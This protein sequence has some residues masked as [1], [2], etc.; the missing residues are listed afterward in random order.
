MAATLRYLTVQDILWIN[1][2]VT[3]KVNRYN[4]AAL[5]EATFYQY[6]YGESDEL[7]P[8][9]ARFLSGFTRKAAFEVGN[10][11]TAFVA[12][13][14]F[15][16]LNHFTQKFEDPG[17]AEWLARALTAPGKQLSEGI[18][19][20]HHHESVRE[21]VTAVVREYPRTI[22]DLGGRPVEIVADGAIH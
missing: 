17:G 22:E 10:D 1:L 12:A 15:L 9:A 19:L 13:L 6:A 5:E 21:S 20:E 3:R 14:A 4:Y 2:Q 16:R 11:A 18:E 7:L 8:Q